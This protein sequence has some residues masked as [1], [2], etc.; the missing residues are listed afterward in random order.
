MVPTQQPASARSSVA[1]STADF[2]TF[3]FW[4]QPSSVNNSPENVKTVKNGGA[5]DQ[6]VIDKIDKKENTPINQKK[7]PIL[8]FDQLLVAYQ[9]EKGP[10]PYQKKNNEQVGE[11]KN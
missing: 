6:K 5:V 10:S 11:Q 9:N 3:D 2:A 7:D 1:K 8:K 4:S